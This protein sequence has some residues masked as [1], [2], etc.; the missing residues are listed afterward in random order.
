MNAKPKKRTKKADDDVD[1]GSGVSIE[2]NQHVTLTFSLKY[3]VNFS[4]SSALT[5][6]VQLMLSNDV[7]L[8]VRACPSPFICYACTLSECDV[9]VGVV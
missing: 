8:L 9:D 5:D 2:M 4:K 7:P 3:L 1:A 6:T